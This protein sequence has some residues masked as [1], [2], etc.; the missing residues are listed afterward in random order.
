MSP[1]RR[2]GGLTLLA[3][4]LMAVVVVAFTPPPPASA[5]NASKS[6]GKRVLKPGMKGRDVRALQ[7]SLT[8]LGYDTPAAGV[9]DTTTKR[10]VKRLERKRG[11]R[12]DGRVTRKD[13]KRITKL[14]AKRKK[15]GMKRG[16]F[17]L[18]GLT[19]PTV[20]VTATAAG[21]VSLNVI[22]DNS[23]L[24]AF[25]FPLYFNGPGTQT[26]AWNGWTAA[27]IWAPDSV[28]RFKLAEP[29][30]AGATLS[31]QTKPFKL[32]RH[33]FPIPGSHSFGG[34]GSRFGASRPGHIH[35]G[36][37]VS[38]A[39]GEK[40]YAT[41]G[42]TVTTKAYQASG[43]GYYLVIHGAITGTDHVYMH[44]KKPS[45]ADQGTTLYAGQQIGKVGS[46][47]ASSGCHLHFERWTAPGWYRGGSPYDP[48]PE[49][50]YWDAYS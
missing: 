33:A 11:W 23:G 25:S 18:A 30:A 34:A 40:L 1:P 44:M 16:L 42:G 10:N 26:I 9:Y 41:E 38:A 20:S 21:S 2:P 24:G 45:W 28:Y 3:A 27:S 7:R 39:C 37:D 13:A 32:R 12:I 6:F 19:Q 48:L 36:Q 17:F 47:G 49:L 15:K 46:T 50:Q 29:G 31:G 5:G 43:A 4:L 14:V 22:D 8:V 35:Q